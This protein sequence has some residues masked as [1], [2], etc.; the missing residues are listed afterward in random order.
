MLAAAADGTP[1]AVAVKAA[2][3]W[4]KRQ[5]AM[6][7]AARR[8]APSMLPALLSRLASLDALAKGLGRGSVWDELREL[9]LALAGRP[10]MAMPQKA[11]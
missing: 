5:A 4:G 1:V 2:R 6:E 11:S 3:V 9:A 10:P 8:V 7:R